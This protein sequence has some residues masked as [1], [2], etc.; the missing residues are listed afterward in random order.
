MLA[1][2]H[3]SRT[4]LAAAAGVILAGCA[5]AAGS[6]AAAQPA[7]G[8]TAPAATPSRAAATWTIATRYHIDLWLHGYAMIEDDT[9]RVPYFVPGYRD[10]MLALEKRANVSSQLMVNRDALRARLAA[11]PQ[12]VG[13]Q[14]LPLYFDSWEGMQRGI[15]LFLRANGDPRRAG[16]RESQQVIAILAASFPTAADRDWLRLFAAGLADE[17][18]RFYR[19]YWD[20]QQRERSPVLTVLDSLWTRVYLPKLQGY[21]NNTQQGSGTIFVSLPLDGEG[22]TISGGGRSNA[23]AVTFPATERAATDA[24]YVFAHEVIGTIANQVIADNTTP[25]EKRTGVAAGYTSAAAVR[26]GTL[27]L[28][29]VAPELVQGYEQYYLRSARVPATDADLDAALAR[30]FPLPAAILDGMRRQIDIVL[31]GI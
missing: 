18:T 16:D 12:L 27:L 29:R 21:L 24:I 15:D 30:T 14:F 31:G 28:A 9:T 22:R 17:S 11:N 13:G 20:Q 3:L 8:A 5:S 23:V 25:A 10:A 2:G 7:A 6:G 4:L 19:S 1:T 26:G